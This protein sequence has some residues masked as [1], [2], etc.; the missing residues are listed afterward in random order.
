MLEAGACSPGSSDGEPDGSSTSPVAARDSLARSLIPTSF[1]KGMFMPPNVCTRPRIPLLFAPISLSVCSHEHPFKPL[2]PSRP[3]RARKR[4]DDLA[5][6]ARP[7]CFVDRRLIRRGVPVVKRRL[8]E[9]AE[10]V[11]RPAQRGCR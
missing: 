10:T 9:L 4:R 2:R 8:P 11:S 3:W 6:F 1:D 7:R 5:I